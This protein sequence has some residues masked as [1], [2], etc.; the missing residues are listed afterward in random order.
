MFTCDDSNIRGA[1]LD[2]FLYDHVTFGGR[3]KT[4]ARVRE[5]GH[6]PKASIAM[7]SYIPFHQVFTGW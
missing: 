4:Y 5:K 6:S 3:Q 2:G 1:W 7:Y